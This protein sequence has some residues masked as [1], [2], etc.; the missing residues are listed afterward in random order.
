MHEVGLD[1]TDYLKHT[2][3]LGRG[4]KKL[5]SHIHHTLIHVQLQHTTESR[6]EST[7]EMTAAA[8]QQMKDEEKEKEKKE[9]EEEEKPQNLVLHAKQNRTRRQNSNG[10]PSL[11]ADMVAQAILTNKQDLSEDTTM[12]VNME[13]QKQ[14][15]A[16]S[17][18]V[19]QPEEPTSDSL[20]LLAK[21]SRGG[22]GQPGVSRRLF[23]QESAASWNRESG[24]ERSV[25]DVKSKVKNSLS[26]LKAKGNS[27]SPL[28]TAK[29]ERTKR[30]K[31]VDKP[32]KTL[33]IASGKAEASLTDTTSKSTKEKPGEGLWTQA[34]LKVPA[35]YGVRKKEVK[36]TAD[37]NQPS[38]VAIAQVAFV[39]PLVQQIPYSIQSLLPMNR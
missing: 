16:S 29:P 15:G 21:I 8:K 32:V 18:S 26:P 4:L 25:E 1:S 2:I 19:K 17:P 13:K 39:S 6:T 22:D 28:T 23:G 31:T 36:A 38:W 37:N 9:T 24:G 3:I 12:E 10:P 27:P 35:D 20:N 5:T 7:K 33:G 14:K 11:S 34:E 30:S